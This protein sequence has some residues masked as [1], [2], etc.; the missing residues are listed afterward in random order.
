[1][2]K[3]NTLYMAAYKEPGPRNVS[4]LVATAPGHDSRMQRAD[5][6]TPRNSVANAPCGTCHSYED[7]KAPL[8]KHLRGVSRIIRV[9]HTFQFRAEAESFL[10][11]AW[12]CC[13]LYLKP[14]PNSP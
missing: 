1:M 2:G 14:M 3:P 12:S 5:C 7:S 13:P 11:F 10:R 4:V 6:I 9:A 8:I